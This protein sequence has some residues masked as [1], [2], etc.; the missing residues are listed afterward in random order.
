MFKVHGNNIY[1]N[2]GD[3][4]SFS[5]TP[6]EDSGEEHVMEVNEFLRLTVMR[7]GFEL[8]HIDTEKGFTTFNITQ[9][10]TSRVGN[11]DYDV[12]LVYPDGSSAVIIG[13]TENFTPH[14]NVLG[15]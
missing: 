3:A 10:Q 7:R 11:F 4:A 6:Y 1:I 12:K 13:A 14:F 9:E 2:R 15:G 8:W 5:V